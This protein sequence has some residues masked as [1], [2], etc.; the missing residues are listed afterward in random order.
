LLSKKEKISNKKIYEV[1]LSNDAA[2]AQGF[3]YEGGDDQALVVFKDP[4]EEGEGEVPGTGMSW[5]VLGEAIGANEQLQPR[6]SGRR[7]QPTREIH[8]EE[9]E[10]ESEDYEEEQ[11]S[12]EDDEDEILGANSFED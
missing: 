9:F 4:D 7:A 12:F 6:R 10:S 11:I 2:E 3:L 8:E 5:A 1:L